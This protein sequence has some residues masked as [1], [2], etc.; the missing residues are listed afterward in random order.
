MKAMELQGE[1]LELFNE[2]V[3][4]DT[5]SIGK[6]KKYIK[7]IA[8]NRYKISRASKVDDIDIVTDEEIE[9]AMRPFT[10]EEKIERLMVAET[11]PVYY[12]QEEMRK[13]AASWRNL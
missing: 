8:S 11:D 4:L 5:E 1:R 6:V 2:I 3:N 10:D 12:T 9:N 7:R 13:A